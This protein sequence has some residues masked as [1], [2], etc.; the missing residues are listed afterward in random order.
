MALL[1]G[2]KLV[3]QG[4]RNVDRVMAEVTHHISLVRRLRLIYVAAV[5][6]ETMQPVRPEIKAGETLLITAVWC[7]EVRL[8]DNVLL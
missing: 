2:K 3:D 4:I 1:E 8:V 6:P 7:D 5:H